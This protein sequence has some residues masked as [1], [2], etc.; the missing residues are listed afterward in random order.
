MKQYLQ[1]EWKK[2][3]KR[4]WFF[5]S[6]A[7]VGLLYVYAFHHR[8]AEVTA[9]QSKID[10]VTADGQKKYAAYT[11][12]MD[13]AVNGLKTYESFQSDPRNPAHLTR[14]VPR[15]GIFGQTP[16]TILSTG[17]SDL[18]NREWTLN[19]WN[20]DPRLVAADIKNPVQLMFGQLDP[21]TVLV[22]LLPLLIIAFSYNVVS[23]E[24]EDGTLKIVSV[25][26]SSIRKWLTAKTLLPALVLFGFFFLETLLLLTVYETNWLSQPLHVLLFAVLLAFYILFWSGL[27]LLVNLYRRSSATNAIWLVGAWLLAVFILPSLLNL[28][29]VQA[30]DVPSRV[31]FISTY[32]TTYGEAERG[33]RQK[34]L[35]KYFFDH[36]E[37]TKPDTSNKK[38]AVNNFPKA[39]AIFYEYVYEKAEPVYADYFGRHQKA[40][41][42]ATTASF[43]SPATLLQS[44]LNVLSNTSQEQFLRFQDSAIRFRTSYLRAVKA[45][46]VQDKEL[47]LE[48]VKALPSFQM[49]AMKL[50]GAAWWVLIGLLVH[51]LLLCWVIQYRFR[52]ATSF[53]H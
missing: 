15:Y 11:R 40:I 28:L 36:P 14:A 18:F 30:F 27:S 42:F 6:I 8:N 46:L 20:R 19:V 53:I 38:Y 41:S 26:A 10:S 16:L 43:L 52:N 3:S 31:A 23:G 37:L 45:K 9:Q 34:T 17:Q 24:R 32:R 5:L 22:L 39:S 2:L 1:L 51:C 35:D 4:S 21:A 33:D 50:S 49:D 25:Q 12:L 13:S 29:A 48:D 7:L 47:T 44:G